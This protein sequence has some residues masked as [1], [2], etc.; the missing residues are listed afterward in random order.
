MS[1]PG[2]LHGPA[3]PALRT[4]SRWLASERRALP[5]NKLPKGFHPS[6]IPPHKWGNKHE[7][8]KTHTM[9]LILCVLAALTAPRC[10][11]SFALQCR[12]P[13]VGSFSISGCRGSSSTPGLSMTLPEGLHRAFGAVLVGGVLLTGNVDGAGVARADVS[14]SPRCEFAPVVCFGKYLVQWVL[15][16]CCL[17]CC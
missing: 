1:R 11:C 7:H 2:A 12:A 5:E 16:R 8:T 4:L 10:A 15:L 14:I 13:A 3:S 9:R 17:C 6:S